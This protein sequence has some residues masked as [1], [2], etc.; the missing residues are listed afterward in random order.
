VT[1]IRALVVDDSVVVRRLVSEALGAEPG[2]EVAGIAADGKIGLA[3]VDQLNP[4]IVILDVEMPVMDGLTTLVEIRRRRPRLPVIMFSTLT[5]RGAAITLDAL[6]L[7]A[8]DYVTKPQA[9]NPER[10]IHLIREEL[11]PRIRALAGEAPAPVERRPA[12]AVSTPVQT[13]PRQGPPPRVD[14]VAIGVSTGGPNALAALIPALPAKLPV[15]V[16]IV[17]HMP[18]MFTKILAERLNATSA[19][20]VVEAA[21][22]DVIAPGGVWVAPGGHH[23]VV[24]RSQLGA[25]IRTNL[26]PPENSCRP[27]V[28]PLFRS[29]A[30]AYGER[31]LA[32][33]LTGMG[34]DGLRGAEQIRRLGGQV[35]A[36]DETTSVV[37]GMPGFIAKAGLADAVLPLPAMAGAILERIAVGRPSIARVGAAS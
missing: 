32:T 34:N 14:I 33:V 31:V 15:P 1:K 7:G 13:K 5:Q 36:Q 10:S 6:A 19:L 30:A 29:V 18:P 4:D 3:K 2:I 23:M 24:E 9:G 35:L 26:E 37:W 11:V 25:R 20:H 17:Q 27:S 16:V 8:S 22:G 12:T 28:E 21:D